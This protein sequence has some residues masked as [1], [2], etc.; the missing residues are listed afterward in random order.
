MNRTERLENLSSA[1]DDE[2]APTE[3]QTL[4]AWVEIHPEDLA[5]FQ[6]IADVV[7]LVRAVGDVEPPADLHERIMR[8]V[9]RTA[10]VEVSR[11]EALEWLDRYFE[12]TLSAP[13]RQ[14]VEH[15]LA[16]D[17][18][19]AETAELHAAMLAALADVGDEEPPADLEDRIRASVGLPVLH[20]L[21]ARPRRRVKI[22]VLARRRL[23]S[24]AAMAAL[25]IG[26]F[27]L[28]R[29]S[30]GATTVAVVPPAKIAPFVPQRPSAQ[31]DL[32]AEATNQPLTNGSGGGAAPAQPATPRTAPPAAGQLANEVNRTPADPIGHRVSTPATTPRPAHAKGSGTT[33]ATP[34]KPTKPVKSTSGSQASAGTGAEIPHVSGNSAKDESLTT[35]GSQG[36]DGNGDRLPFRRTEVPPF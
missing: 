7:G 2:L 34:A 18:D 5:E 14:I 12:D 4:A 33:T 16:V 11:E 13:Q 6:S 22:S 1:I 36:I 28:G 15:Y 35:Q 25:V 24:A 10:P 27:G 19:F 8:A 31:P 26:A 29:H 17:A 21:T 32:P 20:P 9:A 30:G 23:I 3:R